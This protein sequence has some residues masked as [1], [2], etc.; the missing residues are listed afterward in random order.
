MGLDHDNR[1]VERIREAFLE[2][3]RP[4]QLNNFEHPIDG[5]KYSWYST[6]FLNSVGFE[7]DDQDV[8]IVEVNALMLHYMALPGNFT[9][10]DLL[11][12]AQK[13]RTK[14]AM[15]LYEYLA[16]FRG[17]RYLDI[18]H[19]HLMKLLNF[20]PKKSRQRYY[21]AMKDTLVRQLKE[22]AA[23]SDLAE[24]RL[25]D[26]STHR[27]EGIFRIII[28]PKSQQVAK[29]EKVESMIKKI[30]NRI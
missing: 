29:K 3:Q 17:Y 21:S 24:V 13:F 23:K 26:R 8:I 2:L 18:A 7:R 6:V 15:K 25:D 22:I 11:K 27:K 30:I 19:G 1:Y 9:E 14:H 16:S 20:D 12:Y 10:I 28:D 5:I 4:I